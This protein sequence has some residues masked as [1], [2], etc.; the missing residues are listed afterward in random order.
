MWA[1]MM[2]QQ[3]KETEFFLLEMAN[4]NYITWV[5]FENILVTFSW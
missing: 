2:H 3:Q 1:L 5:I 4:L